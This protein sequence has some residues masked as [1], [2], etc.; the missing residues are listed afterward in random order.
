[1]GF[2]DTAEATPQG[3]WQS[4]SRIHVAKHARKREDKPA[5]KHARAQSLRSRI[6]TPLASFGLVAAV[7]AALLAGIG[8]GHRARTGST[9]SPNSSNEL[10][11]LSA[12]AILN[13]D[14]PPTPRTV[15]PQTTPATQPFSRTNTTQPPA[16]TTTVAPTTPLFPTHAAHARSV[17]RQWTYRSPTASTTTTV[18]T[19]PA[20]SSTPATTTITTVTTKPTAAAKGQTAP[21]TP[22]TTTVKKSTATTTTTTTVKITPTTTTTTIVQTVPTTT[23]T[24]TTAPKASPVV[25]TSF[26][27]GAYAGGDN[28]AGIAA[29]DAATGTHVSLATDYLPGDNGW[30]GMDGSSGTAV[31]Q[32]AHI[33]ASTGDALSL[34]VPIIPTSGGAPVGTLATG[35]TGA[36]NS[37]FVTLAQTLVNGGE[38]NAYLRLGWEFDG[39][40]FPWNATT[41]ANEASFAT[42]FQQ[43]VTSMR[44]V[45][46][47]NFKF[48]WN[49]D[50]G[51][52]TTAGYN[53]ALA[54][55]GSA[56]V[57]DIGLDTYDS[58]WATPFTPA[59]AWNQTQLPSLTAAHGF[60]ASQGKPLAICEWGTAIRSDGHGL[61]DD[62]LFVTNFLDWMKNAAD[63]VAYESYF[64]ADSGGV[65]SLIT[66]GS[67]P[68]SL[69]AFKAALG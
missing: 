18:T 19:K 34:A 66:G 21:T 15:P 42:Y 56:Y 54:Y 37:Y 47:S 44:S 24:T 8:G 30:A 40:W 7:I 36:Y 60:A 26:L 43:I 27:E 29:F 22:A 25:P 39:S 11:P 69:A 55:P 57:N 4:T 1:M 23:T 67:F 2:D 14:T 45:A 41:P 17:M 50:A 32:L 12:P 53:V 51:A 33:W 10:G 61:G 5:P 52:F 48:V 63:D 3:P 38:A 46:G 20:T 28:P 35:A 65:N 13:T 58:S 49:P 9:D 31:S 62:P 64:D 59:N 6:L 68:N 16:P